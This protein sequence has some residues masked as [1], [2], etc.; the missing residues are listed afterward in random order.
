MSNPFFSDDQE[1]RQTLHSNGIFGFST[2]SLRN[3]L[4]E[5]S[6]DLEKGA[7]L[8]MGAAFAI[9][10]APETLGLGS[11][12]AGV[13]GYKVGGTTMRMVTRKIRN[14]ISEELQEE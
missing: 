4:D 7:G 12:A 11:A 8:A 3:Y 13:V 2:R 9:M 1:A 6:D 14:F 5:H 10:A